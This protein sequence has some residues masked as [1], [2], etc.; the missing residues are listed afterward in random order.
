MLFPS[1]KNNILVCTCVNVSIMICLLKWNT[2]IK[3][4]LYIKYSKKRLSFT[5]LP[6]KMNYTLCHIVSF[7]CTIVGYVILAV[8][9]DHVMHFLECYLLIY[10]LECLKYEFFLL[11]LFFCGTES[12]KVYQNV[13]LWSITNPR[14][15]MDYWCIVGNEVRRICGS[16]VCEWVEKSLS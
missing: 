9:Y 4:F 13:R 5:W 10:N 1:L 8:I 14:R 7:K 15:V 3:P 6:V 16:T 2:I 12:S 11:K